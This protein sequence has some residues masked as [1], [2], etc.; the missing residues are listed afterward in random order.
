MKYF[1]IELGFLP[2]QE[3]LQSETQRADDSEK[4]CTEALE[5][6]E[7]RSKKLEET[8]RRVHQLQESLSR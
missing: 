6:R 4:K 2:T 8:E 5:S 7:E 1:V 3:L